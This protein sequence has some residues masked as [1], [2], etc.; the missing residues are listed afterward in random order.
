M[1][2][3]GFGWHKAEKSIHFAIFYSQENKE[4]RLKI[5]EH[6]PKT[7]GRLPRPTFIWYARS[8]A[9][10]D[11]GTAAGH[12]YG[13]LADCAKR[14][15]GKFNVIITTTESEIAFWEV[16]NL[17]WE[18]CQQEKKKDSFCCCGC[19]YYIVQRRTVYKSNIQRRKKTKAFTACSKNISTTRP[20]C[21]G[22]RTGS[23]GGD[24]W[25]VVLSTVHHWLLSQCVSTLLRITCQRIL[26]KKFKNYI[27]KMFTSLR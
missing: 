2:L 18:T 7:P 27:A 17:V 22:K 15:N 16:V 25:N 21:I 8:L 1:I 26:I 9:P 4:A 24:D 14:I 3:E 6:A 5:V 19:F 11:L 20:P 12:H 10:F 13:G 23:C